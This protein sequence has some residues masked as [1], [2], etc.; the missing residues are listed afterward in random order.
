MACSPQRRRTP[1]WTI[2]KFLVQSSEPWPTRKLD[3]SSTLL[4]VYRSFVRRGLD[5]EAVPL[6]PPSSSMIW[7]FTLDE[8]CNGDDDD[9]SPEK[10]DRRGAGRMDLDWGDGPSPA[11]QQPLTSGLGLPQRTILCQGFSL[12]TS[13]SWI[14]ENTDDQVL[15]ACL[16]S[17]ITGHR[18]L[19][20]QDA[21]YAIS[22]QPNLSNGQFSATC[23]M[24]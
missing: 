2:R 10:E 15:S 5:S 24:G 22:H 14:D 11:T 1:N 19:N 12:L 13:S 8:L 9:P 7:C 23:A 17:Q 6:Y 21:K 3:I 20:G 18:C 4:G 16:K